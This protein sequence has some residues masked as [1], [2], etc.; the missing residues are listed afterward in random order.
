MGPT[1]TSWTVSSVDTSGNPC[2][3]Y[4]LFYD[5]QPIKQVLSPIRQF[6]EK[7]CISSSFVY[8]LRFAASCIFLYVGGW[9]VGGGGDLDSVG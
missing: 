8:Q 2:P 4:D 7:L 9:G 1:T 6:P 5:F 3:I